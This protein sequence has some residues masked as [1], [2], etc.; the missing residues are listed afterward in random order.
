VYVYTDDVT[1]R[2]LSIADDVY[3]RLRRMKLKGE[4]FSDTI[5]RLTDRGR[6]EE[7]V[8]LW[9]DMRAEDLE[10]IESVISE[11]RSTATRELVNRLDRS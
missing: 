11:T 4:S 6:L 9:S 2:T 8:G 1:T 10:R 3:K 7:C 5:R